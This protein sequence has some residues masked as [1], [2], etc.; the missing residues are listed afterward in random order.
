M[1]I[2]H[3]LFQNNFTTSL[4]DVERILGCVSPRLRVSC[5]DCVAVLGSPLAA[6]QEKGIASQKLDQGS[7][8]LKTP[9]SGDLLL[10][11]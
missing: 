9:G 3:Q 1:H 4:F 2:T 10:S 5:Y 8:R 7:G 11:G 6:P